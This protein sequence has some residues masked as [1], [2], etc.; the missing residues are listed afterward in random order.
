MSGLVGGTE[1]AHVE[2]AASMDNWDQLMEFASD[3]IDQA[4]SD[5]SQSYKMKLAY[6][7]LISNIIRATNHAST[8]TNPT[9]LEV[10]ALRGSL[11]G[12][13]VFVIRTRDTGPHF[14]PGFNNRKGIDVDQPVHEREIGGLGLF[15]IQQSVDYVAYEWIDGKNTYDLCVRI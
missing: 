13:Q 2:A 9:T 5:K 12:Q 15:L 6:E 7:E 1:V 10:L 11:E 3:Q 14:E 4:V 8:S